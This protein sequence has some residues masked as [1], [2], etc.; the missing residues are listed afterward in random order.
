M[1]NHCIDVICLD[2]GR[3][4]CCRGCSSSDEDKPSQES[5]DRW[6]RHLKEWN[7]R[8]RQGQ[9]PYQGTKADEH[10]TCGSDNVYMD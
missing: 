3:T 6:K 2:C 4:W 7:D 1:G 9:E 10:C 5:V 8:W